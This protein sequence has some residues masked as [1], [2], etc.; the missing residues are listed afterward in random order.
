MKSSFFQLFKI[1]ETRRRILTTLGLLLV[2]R[3]G[4]Q[5]P[6]PGMSP[7][8]LTANRGESLFGLMSSLVAQNR[9]DEAV[10]VRQEYQN[11]WRLAEAP[12][13]LDALR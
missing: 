1:E 3:L 2:E 11:A 13:T 6:I 8:F 5:V 4:F 9:S 7:E 10:L 12:M